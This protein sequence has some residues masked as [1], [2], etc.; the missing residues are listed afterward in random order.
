MRHL[1]EEWTEQLPKHLGLIRAENCASQLGKDPTID[2][3]R[4]ILTMRYHN[5]RLLIHRVVL[6]RLCDSL[7]DLNSRSQEILALQD[8]AWSTMQIATDSAT[9]IITIV[10]T[11]VESDLVRRG[12]LG[13]WWFTLYYSMSFFLMAMLSIINGL[14]VAFDAALVLFTVFLLTKR[15]DFLKLWT[16]STTPD[17]MKQ[18]FIGCIGPLRR[19]DEG[20]RTIDKCCRCL[21]RL[22]EAWNLIGIIFSVILSKLKLFY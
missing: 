21:Q 8:V 5:I 22:A 6:V 13:E 17:L 3:F 12:L 20:N 9:E 1:L 10:R 4:T 11:V 18:A 14:H 7:D 19:L 16:P 2:R 15:S